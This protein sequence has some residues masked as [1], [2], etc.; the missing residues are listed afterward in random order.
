M[1]N[2][3]IAVIPGDGIG[4]EV[5]H[6]GLRVLERIAEIDGG[7]SVSYDHYDWG[8]EYYTKTGRMM[9]ADGMERLRDTDAI[10]LGAVGFPGVPDHISLRELLLRI[11]QG[12]DQY[13]NFRPVKLLTDLDCPLK[14]KGPADLD[15]VFVRENTEG[16]YA[17]VGGR[18]KHGTPDE[19][20]VQTSVFTRKTTERVMRYAYDL[21][22]S[23][24]EQRKA[25]GRKTVSK[26]TSVTK[27]NALNHSLV[28]WDEVFAEIGA[29]YPDITTDQYHVDAMSMYMIQRPED[30]DVV[31]ASNLFG[32]ILTDLGGVL[33]GGLGFAAGGN[34][35]PEREY[36]SM[37]EPVHGSAPTI[38]GKNIA[39]PIAMV[40]TVK[41]M[42]DFL[43]HDAA[44]AAVLQAIEQAVT[45][46]R[47]LLTGDMG[48]GGSTSSV[49]DILVKSLG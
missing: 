43:G 24:A 16:E 14:G 45:G 37:F 3:S 28:F 19:T 5:M 4:T 38:A 21:A 36:P 2:Y 29:D 25:L 22:Q 6:E 41:L 26:L 8:C 48:G 13:V 32:D 11:R 33:Q 47:S 40:W 42:L 20:V 34:L 31:V 7:F 23:R 49:G 12:F 27:S 17:G 39:N 1:K 46:D 18:I 15:M 30:F 35:N 9:A 44:G 10:L